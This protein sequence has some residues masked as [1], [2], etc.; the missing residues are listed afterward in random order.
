M[1]GVEHGKGWVGCGGMAE[2]LEP[3]GKIGGEGGCFW[4]IFCFFVRELVGGI[5]AE[6]EV[7]T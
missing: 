5:Y 3:D 4:V 6:N 1:F 2:K 7:L